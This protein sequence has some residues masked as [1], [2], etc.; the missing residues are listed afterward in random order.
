MNFSLVAIPGLPDMF[1]EYKLK[2]HS[3]WLRETLGHQIPGARIM[4]YH[5]DF[6]Q[7]PSD[8]AWKSLSYPFLGLL[9]AL[10]HRRE[11]V[12]EARRPDNFVAYGLGALILKKVIMYL[13]SELPFKPL[14]TIQALIEASRLPAFRKIFDNTLGIVFLAAL[15]NEENPHFEISWLRCA[16]VELGAMGKENSV[17]ELLRRSGD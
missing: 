2:D 8:L 4:S 1:P 7:A 17:V 11:S 15:H 3:T 5:Y 6:G 12:H 9:I 13:I 10:V 14:K 16:V